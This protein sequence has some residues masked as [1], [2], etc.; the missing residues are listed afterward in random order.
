MKKLGSLVLVLFAINNVVFPQSIA[1]LVKI[2]SLK[3]YVRELSGDLPVTINGVTSYIKSRNTF[4]P[5][6]NIS[7]A[8]E[9]IK[10]KFKSFGFSPI[11]QSFTAEGYSAKNIIAIQEGSKYPD[12]EFIICAHYDSMP[13]VGLAPGADDNA[14]GTSCVIEAARI[15]SQSSPEYTV[16][17]VAFSGEEQGLY[18]SY[19]YVNQA[20]EK[21][22]TILGVINLDM[23]AWNSTG[24][25]IVEIYY[26]NIGNGNQVHEDELLNKVTLVNS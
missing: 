24:K 10:S 19:Y 3:K 20:L 23:I 16:K 8:A 13:E 22:E 17:F 21:K 11:E 5:H 14:S 26:K 1:N 12:R 25:N 6:T 15:F 18:G 2:D 4:N 9:Y 7:D